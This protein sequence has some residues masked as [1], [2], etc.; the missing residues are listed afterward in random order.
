MCTMI[1]K[2]K[3]LHTNTSIEFLSMPYHTVM[4]WKYLT[5]NEDDKSNRNANAAVKKVN[6]KNVL[7]MKNCT[8][9]P[10]VRNFLKKY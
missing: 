5:V 9:F 10:Q 2:H 4:V 6:D 3:H 1:I 7:K 8:S